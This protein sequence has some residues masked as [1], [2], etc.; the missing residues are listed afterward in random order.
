MASGS[1]GLGSSKKSAKSTKAIAA[2]Q[3][4]SKTRTKKGAPGGGRNIPWMTLG[5]VAV[6]AA[7][8]VALGISQ[9]GRAHV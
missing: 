7:L 9:I 8:I 6:V 4:K 1:D 5:G 2:A 3:K